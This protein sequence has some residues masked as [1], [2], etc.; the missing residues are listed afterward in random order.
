MK[1]IKSRIAFEIAVRGLIS[2]YWKGKITGSEF[3]KELL[4]LV[5]KAYYFAWGKGAESCGIGPEERTSEE[6][7]RLEG[8][9]EEQVQYIEKLA[10]DIETGD[11]VALL[12][13]A[14]LWGSRYDYVT[15]VGKAMACGDQKEIWISGDTSEPCVDCSEMDGRVY[16]LSTW[17]KYGIHPASPRLACKGYF[18]TCRREVT[19][20][21]VTPGPPPFLRGGF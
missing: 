19:E 11:V 9:I 12:N 1:M 17:D 15:E 20:E 7:E 21:P 14:T 2:V 10:T 8:L 13:R 6:Q 4:I 5:N 3:K 18:C 16:R